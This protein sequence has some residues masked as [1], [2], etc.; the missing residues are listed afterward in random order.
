MHKIWY[1]NLNFAY[2]DSHLACGYEA[3]HLTRHAPISSFLEE[4]GNGRNIVR[5]TESTDDSSASRLSGG[6]LRC[7]R[8]RVIVHLLPSPFW[9]HLKTSTTKWPCWS[10]KPVLFFDTNP[11]R[12]ILNRF[13]KE[14]GFMDNLLP[15]TFLYDSIA[16]LSTLFVTIIPTT[17]NYWLLMSSS[18][19]FCSIYLFVLR[20]TPQSLLESWRRLEPSS[21]VLCIHISQKQYVLEGV[22]TVKTWAVDNV[23]ENGSHQGIASKDESCAYR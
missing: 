22:H 19:N 15:A 5:W 11:V 7:R 14:V 13:S 4:M 8:S 21:A 6:G 16:C 12:P 23:S 9:R 10:L 1:I 18:S 3:T 17:V 20:I 2:K